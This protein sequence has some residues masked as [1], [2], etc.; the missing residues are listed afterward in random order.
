M[1]EEKRSRIVL[2]PMNAKERLRFV[3]ALRTDPELF[4][5]LMERCAEE[6]GLIEPAPPPKLRR[7]GLE[8]D[9]P[10]DWN[11]HRTMLRQTLSQAEQILR[12]AKS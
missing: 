4:A 3:K 10:A 9:G 5:I 11:A 2:P 7:N 6:M 8:F 12:E 1:S